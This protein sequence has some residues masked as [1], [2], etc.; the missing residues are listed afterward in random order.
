MP[1]LFISYRRADTI[2]DVGRLYD[3]L[4]L[5]RDYERGGIFRD[6]D[7]IAAGKDFTEAV[8]A[9][10]NLT[11]V[12]LVVIG[13]DWLN[14][15]KETGRRRLDN[16]DDPVRE[17]ITAALTA[18]VPLLP[19]LVRKADMP[20][21]NDLPDPIRP[22]ILVNAAELSDSH[23][24]F[25]FAAL[26]QAITELVETAAEN[27]RKRE[28]QTT[29]E[30]YYRIGMHYLMKKEEGFRLANASLRKAARLLPEMTGAHRGLCTSLQ[31]EAH[32]ML[33]ANNFGLARELIE[34]VEEHAKL[35]TQGRDDDP[36]LLAQL[37]YNRKEL[38][39]AYLGINRPEAASEPIQKARAHFELAL[40][41][42]PHDV[43]ALNGMGSM[44]FIAGAYD[45]AIAYS[46]KALEHEPK[47]VDALYDLTRAHYSKA[48]GLKD[49]LD[50]IQ[51]LAKVLTVYKQLAD[52]KGDPAAEALST[53]AQGHVD[54]I[55]VHAFKEA[56]RL[57]DWVIRQYELDEKSAQSS[58]V[59]ELL[60]HKHAAS[61]PAQV[62]S[63]TST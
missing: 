45:Q 57:K 17:E 13:P 63:T 16:T 52:L 34:E 23:Y 27:P 20:K 61:T 44:A 19:V 62:L 38:A 36:Q 1:R 8:R 54:A 41:L 14:S 29:P 60:S 5:V 59:L 11:D 32:A 39:Q 10:I 49:G 50:K 25:D 3:R 47:Y 2:A 46:T 21:A 40:A 7:G 35:A 56:T 24:N 51:E 9:A 58:C 28:I 15:G 6:M 12:M 33:V 43:S 31:L 30:S 48:L 4:K 26:Q 22:L 42:D 53:E 37:G 18:R 55:C